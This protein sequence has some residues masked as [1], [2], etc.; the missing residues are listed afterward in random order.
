MKGTIDNHG[1]GSWT[2][3]DF[4]K[5]DQYLLTSC[6]RYTSSV[7][8]PIDKRIR[9][10]ST[11]TLELVRD[12]EGH[13]NNVKYAE[14]SPDDR[15]IVSAS[16]DG[17]AKVWDVASGNIVADFTI[18]N[19]SVEYAAFFPDGERVL[20]IGKDR[21]AL[22]WNV[23][24]T[25]VEKTLENL[26]FPA[27]L[28]PDGRHLFAGSEVWDIETGQII[29]ILDDFAQD[30]ACLTLSPDGTQ[31]LTSEE[32]GLTKIWNVP[33]HIL[34]LSGIEHFRVYEEVEKK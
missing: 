17:T 31:L 2:C 13:G 14:F 32:K 18:H 22:I 9:L 25:Q 8:A 11:E 3:F 16:L 7:D 28:S 5:N 19:A 29:K 20:S 10:W 6:G 26:H 33:D 24:T 1:S 15:R 4:T 21:R 34:K 12:F 30:Y 23:E 27:K